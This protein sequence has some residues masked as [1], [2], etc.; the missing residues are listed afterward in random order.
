MT[1]WPMWLRQVNKRLVQVQE[2]FIRNQRVFGYPF[3]LT[4]ESGNFCNLKCPLCATT[5]REKEMPR[6]MLDAETAK[7]ILDRF[8]ALLVANLSLWGEP[9][10]NK[11][12]FDIIRYGRERKIE[13]IV[14]SNFSLPNFDE[15]M[16]QNILDSDLSTLWLSIDGATQE[17]YEVYRRKGELALVLE[18]LGTLLRLKRAQGRTNPK[19]V[20]KMVVNKHNQHEVPLA[21]AKANELGIEFLTVEIYTP[22]HLKEQWKPSVDVEQMGTKTHTDRMEQCYPLWQVMTVNFN[23]DVFPCCGEWSP[24]DAMGNVLREPVSKIWNSPEYRRRRAMNKSGPPRCDDCHIDKETNYQRMWQ[25]REE[26]D[27]NPKMLPI[28]SS[29]P[30]EVPMSGCGAPR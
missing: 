28:L 29:P 23:G 16:A 6:G 22:E 27:V 8:P 21:Q 20:W 3:Y 30:V 4:L 19:I 17:T 11:Q 9:F 26:A 15:E 25:P 14:Q 18:N 12:I 24:K 1:H 7:R 5:F 2:M 10:L 13:M